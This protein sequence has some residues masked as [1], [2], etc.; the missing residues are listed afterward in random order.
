MA[1][2]KGKRLVTRD[3]I[4]AGPRSVA[5]IFEKKGINVNIMEVE[6]VL[7]K[8]FNKDFYDLLLVS[9]MSGD[10]TAV[11]KTIKKVY[12]KTVIIGG[13]ITSEPINSLKNTG[14]DIAV[15]GEGEETLLDL[16]TL[17]LNNIESLP[18]EK[19]ESIK[20]LSFLNKN[21]KIV[22]NGLRPVMQRKT[23]NTFKPS[24]KTIKNYS[25]FY[26]ARV[27]LE[28]LRGCSNYYRANIEQNEACSLC[29]KCREGKLIDRFYCPQNKLPGCGYC[30]VPS[31]FGPPKSRTVDNIIEEAKG[32][33][34]LGVNRIVLSAPC[35][36]DYG[37]DLL[38]EPEP[39][40]DPRFP[41]PNYEELE[42]LFSKLFDLSKVKEGAASIMI[43]NIKA[44]LITDRSATLLGQYFKN[45][46]ISIGFETG[47]KEHSKL[48]GRP[49][50]PSETLNA[51]K[52]LKNTGIKPYVYF[53]HGLPGQTRKTALETVNSINESI[54]NGAERIILYRFH[55]L[56]MSEFCN[57][58]NGLPYV[59]DKNSKIIHE[60]AIKANR[61]KK[62]DLIGKKVNVVIAE[63]YDKNP[64]Y[65]VS[66]PLKHGPVVLVEGKNGLENNVINVEITRKA[67]DRMV[68]GRF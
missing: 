26:A 44:S 68:Y 14:A 6:K 63:R 23:Y 61:L 4:G 42:K 24:I 46:P 13:P 11:R 5:G 53:I 56:P 21:K 33:L 19:L 47:S 43:E 16:L 37:R 30:S 66:Y 12:G 3:A 59:K 25:I 60:A 50:N 67:S 15:I 20:G 48:L 10:L 28:V 35:I 58:P 32:L 52:K 8:S 7:G 22:F 34:E 31:L 40:T 57:Y 29:N 27:Y 62:D 38:V 17:D 45:T 1:S 2:G 49:S 36:L 64:L 9:G 39:L 65:Y 41:E 51:I 55:T 18:L 54:R